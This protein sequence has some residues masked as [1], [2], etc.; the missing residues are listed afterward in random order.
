MLNF[1]KWKI[2]IIIAICFAALIAVIPT[3]A[4]KTRNLSFMH[5]K[6]INL[7]LDLRGGSYLLLEIDFDSYF[8]EQMQG[9]RSDV[10]SS[11]R[12]K[13]IDGKRIGYKGGI[14]L[15]GNSVALTLS[16]VSTADQVI[17]IIKDISRDLRVKNA[18][19]RLKI[20]YTEEYI[21][22]LKRNVLEQSIE[23]VRRRVDETGTREPDIQM[24]GEDRILLQVPGLDNPENLKR[25]LGKTA[26]MT[27]HLLDENR[28]YPDNALS[29]VA[30]GSKRLPEDKGENSYVIRNKVM[31]EGDLL[32]DA[33][34]GFSQSG[35][36]V[37][38]IRFNN[39]GAKKFGDITKNNVGKPFAIVLDN[40][41]LTAPVIRSAI[42]G[43]TAEISGSFSTQ[44][45]NDLAIL[46]RAGSLPAPLDIVEERTVGPSLGADSIEAGKKAIILAII[47]VVVFMLLS[48]GRFG[49]YSDIALAMNIVLIVAVIS[50]FGAT[51]TLPGIAGIVLT[52][53]MA[54]DANVLIFERIKEEMQNG[55]TPYAA[56]DNGFSSA[57][58]TIL[59]SNVTTLIA[60]A[61]LFAFGSGPVKG[62]AVTLSV[63]IICSMFSAILLTR[64]MVVTWLKKNKPKTLPI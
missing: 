12:G 36:S 1:S 29:P 46:L 6:T 63:G 38:N 24:Q 10:R 64:L 31:I 3:F 21:K 44:E 18:N 19:G 15:V 62:F 2:A 49:L 22:T 9:L 61:I 17:K 48:Y 58:R 26:K 34:P 16:N 50:L 45:A 28:P 33:R 51:L 27:F 5:D 56:V 59:D 43:G 25:L 8:K 42:L 52:M 41:V 55:K 40:K 57:F 7:G 14:N 20:S 13:T 54:V 35:Q 39:Q 37:V 4:P 30:A 32:V 23:I 53:G 60:A 47:L 11:F